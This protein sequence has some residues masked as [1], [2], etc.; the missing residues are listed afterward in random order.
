M[1]HTTSPHRRSVLASSNDQLLLLLQ[2]FNHILTDLQRTG[3]DIARC[4]GEPLRQTDINNS[5]TLIQ[6]DPDQCLILAGILD[7]VT[8]VIREDGSITSTELES[9]S[10]CTAQ[11]GRG[12][13]GTLGEEEPFF[14]LCTGCVSRLSS[15]S[16]RV[17]SL[18]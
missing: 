1:A 15:A 12:A 3:H 5:I 6:L 7:I 11:E 13:G 10:V 18:E 14:C 9:P 2:T 4:E 16:T 17:K 8:A